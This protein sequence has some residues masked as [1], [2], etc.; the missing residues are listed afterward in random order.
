[1]IA[2]QAIRRT[3]QAP[4]T[5]ADKIPCILQ[6]REHAVL[7]SGAYCF[8]DV[9]RTSGPTAES[10]LKGRIQDLLKR[11]GRLYYSL[12]L[13]L[14]PVWGCYRTRRKRRE[15]L[16]K[17]DH[18]SVILDLGSGPQRCMSREDIINLDLFPFD[19]VDIVADAGDLPVESDSVDLII[20]VAMLEHAVDPANI[21][22]QMHRVTKR[23]GD[24]FCFVPF[25]QPFHAAPHDYQRW[26]MPGAKAL[27]SQF[28][29]VEVVVAAGPTSGL[30]WIV[31]EWLATALSF[32]SRVVHDALLLMLMVLTF[33]VKFLDELLCAFPGSQNVASGFFVFAR[34]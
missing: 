6:P 27:F 25:M 10:G 33:P 20:N 8:L 3:S 31:Q 17:H 2:S 32:G 29:D 15:L 1:M 28:R 26:T 5:K 30:L 23:G 4:T 11:Y 12:L 22:G 9:E 16:A 21:V 13:L 18:K 7:D 24:V 19:E 14:G 34:K